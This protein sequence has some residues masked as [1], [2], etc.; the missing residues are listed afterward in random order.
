MSFYDIPHYKSYE[1]F[2]KR[3]KEVAPYKKSNSWPLGARAY[4]ARHFT[5]R[6][7]VEGKHVDLFYA[8]RLLREGVESGAP[9]FEHAK[10]RVDRDWIAR[11][12][13]NNTVAFYRPINMANAPLL[14]RT[15]GVHICQDSKRGGAVLRSGDRVYPLFEG[16][17]FLLGSFQ[18]TNPV[19]IVQHRV[20]RKKV[21]EA[22]K[23]S[24]EFLN[25]YPAL[26]RAMTFHGFQEVMNDLNEQ[27][28]NL[29]NQRKSMIMQT[30]REMIDKKHYVDA[31]IAYGGWYAGDWRLRSM[32]VH[33]PGSRGLS[34]SNVVD[35]FQ[36]ILS[37]NNFRRAI[38]MGYEAFDQRI[39]PIGEL[40]QSGWETEVYHYGHIVNRL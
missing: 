29:Q 21:D 19:K 20:N 17:R 26:L 8:R 16:A 38:T 28:P 23:A 10:N 27:Y 31:A 22:M 25:T 35:A 34:E 18:L 40:P 36:K 39:I 30:I 37:G 1:D 15:F 4:S 9:E 14:S 6:E 12:S 5:P 7:D 2:E 13:S 11:V 3:M 33:G 24:A 32:L